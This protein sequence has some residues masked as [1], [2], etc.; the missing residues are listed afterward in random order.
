[1]KGLFGPPNEIMICFTGLFN[2]SNNNN[3]NNNFIVFETWSHS[4]ILVNLELIM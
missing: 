4:V 1:M 3:N 2:N